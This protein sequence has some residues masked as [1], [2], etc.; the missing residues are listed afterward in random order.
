MK[1]LTGEELVEGIELIVRVSTERR[2]E[3]ISRL[4]RLA[5]VE[6]ENKEL[7]EQAMEL[8]GLA[9][10]AEIVGGISV[11]RPGIR[12]WCDKIFKLLREHEAKETP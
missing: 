8:A 4:A 9:S 2:N 11:N 5:E 6:K 10:Y 3:I 12:K 1:E 7:K